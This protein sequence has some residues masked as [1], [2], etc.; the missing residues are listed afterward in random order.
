MEPGPLTPPR[1]R[2]RGRPVGSDSEATRVQIL[3]AARAVIAERGYHAAT[4]QQIALRAGV[5]RPTLHYYFATRDE[6]YEILLRDAYTRVAECAVA[7]QGESG[8][9]NQLTVFIEQMQRLVLPDAAAMQFL[10]TARLEHHR[11]RPRTDAADAVVASVHG[12]YHSIV[13]Q[14]I[15]HGELA[16]DSD[17]RAVAD[18]LAALFWGMGFYAGFVDATGATEIAR[19]LLRMFET[20][21]LDQRVG[22]PVQA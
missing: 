17:P 13:M 19:Q 15:A 1:T 9:Q 18:M 10:V 4:F 2:G 12:F 5:S 14:A 7:A 20:G 21:L 16:A 8:L 6:V 3:D 22:A 11:G